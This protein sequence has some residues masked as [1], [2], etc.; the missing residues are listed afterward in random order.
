MTISAF[1]ISIGEARRIAEVANAFGIEGVRVNLSFS[2]SPHDGATI[3]RGSATRLP[4]SPAQLV[5]PWW[6]IAV[7]GA[8]ERRL[9][10]C[11]PLRTEEDAANVLT[12][13]FAEICSPA[14]FEVVARL[15]DV[16]SV[17]RFADVHLE[18]VRVHLRTLGEGP[19]FYGRSPR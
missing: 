16:A 19:M 14:A 17:H 9:A 6:F 10:P 11:Q 12:V 8:V 15:G 2:G 13:L 18:H 5:G 1:Y 3:A 4:E 7:C